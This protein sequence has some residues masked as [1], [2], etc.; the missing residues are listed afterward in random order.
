MDGKKVFGK[1][2]WTAFW[3]TLLISLAVYFYTQAPTVTL[4]ESGELVVAADH[5]GVPH[6]PGY[7]LWTV[8]SWLFTVVFSFVKYRGHPNPAWAVN[9]VSAVFGAFTCA[10][11][12]L[13]VARPGLDLIR[14]VFPDSK[15]DYS[16][17]RTTCGVCAGLL[18]AFSPIMWSQSVI[19]EVYTLNTFLHILIL[20]CAYLWMQDRTKHKYFYWAALMFGLAFTNYQPIVLIIPALMMVIW[21]RDRKLFRDCVAT[22]FLAFALVLFIKV[23]T[24]EPAE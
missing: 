19:A 24:S 20:I 2:G 14:G 23:H 18:L 1:S 16:V 11:V 7:P 8:V 4:E 9:F 3:I 13:L 5:L 10:F 22:L 12:S 15:K 6:P 21:F 17:L